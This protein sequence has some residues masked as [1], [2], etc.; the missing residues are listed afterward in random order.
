[1]LALVERGRELAILEIT[2]YRAAIALVDASRARLF[3]YDRTADETGIHEDLVEHADLVNPARHKRPSE[4]FSDSGHTGG[5]TYGFDDHREAHIAHLD[6]EFARTVLAALREIIDEF[7]TRRVIIAAG[8][9]MLGKLRTAAPGLLPD[10]IEVLEL[11]HDLVRLHRND[12]LE[13][14]AEHVLVPPAVAA[15]ARW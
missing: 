5:L 14:L 10:D 6:V 9:R 2:M 4:L 1:M 13:R 11:P 15:N 3:T 8:P 12:L 7:P